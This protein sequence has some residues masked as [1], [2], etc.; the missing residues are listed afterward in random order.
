[1][2]S[3]PYDFS[4]DRR[5]AHVRVLLIVRSRDRLRLAYYAPRKD[6]M[7]RASKAQLSL[8]E[9]NLA[10]GGQAPAVARA[11][12][13]RDTPENILEAQ[14]KHCLA[15]HGYTSI[16]Q[17]TGAVLPVRIARQLQQGQISFEQAM[18][19][20]IHLNEAGTCDWISFKPLIAAGARPLDAPWPW[21]GFYW[22]CKS[23]GRKPTDVQF[24]WLHKHQRCGIESVWF[25]R[26][27]SKDQPAPAGEPRN[28]HT[29]E[30]WFF[31]YFMKEGGAR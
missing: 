15:W 12:R 29:F 7:V 28:S 18:R 14:I 31:D 6:P 21:R 9:A 1:M 23:R 2:P 25:D 26:F 3:S 5:Q 13:Q 11:R 24:E 17:H 30:V 20:V 4:V 19:N 27:S 22:E 10:R 8:L 16:R